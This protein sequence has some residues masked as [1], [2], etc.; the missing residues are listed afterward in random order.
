MKIYKTLKGFLNMVKEVEQTQVISLKG[1]EKL[2]TDDQLLVGTLVAG[3]GNDLTELFDSNP[4]LLK[5]AK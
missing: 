5:E 3:L 4:E 2:S 1:Y